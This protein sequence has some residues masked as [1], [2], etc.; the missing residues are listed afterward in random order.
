M[1]IALANQKGGVGKT[2]L[3]LNLA[4]GLCLRGKSVL[5]VD[6]DPQASALEWAEQRTKPCAFSVVGLPHKKIHHEL[7]KIKKS[8]DVIVIDCPPRVSNITRSAIIAS[9]LIVV[10]VTPSPYDLWASAE[11]LELVAEAKMFRPNLITRF[12]INMKINNTNLARDFTLALLEMNILTFKTELVR[13]VVYPHSATQGL[14]V[15]DFEQ[16]FDEKA[17]SEINNLLDEVMSCLP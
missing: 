11:L 5:V 7:E 3:S 4:Q 13:R 1:I 15:F 2:T 9:D 6:A 10:P 14:T 16:A 17:T 12:V 8:F